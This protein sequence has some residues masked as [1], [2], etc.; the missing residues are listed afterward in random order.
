[1]GRGKNLNNDIIDQRLRN[2]T[3]S[4]VQGCNYINSR[5]KMWF[6]CHICGEEWSTTYNHIFNGTG[7]PSAFCLDCGPKTTRLND[8]I[9]DQRLVGRNIKRLSHCESG[10]EMCHFRCEDCN[11]HW[12]VPA[13]NVV[14][15]VNSDQLSGCPQCAGNLPITNEYVDKQLLGRN[16][17]RLSNIIGNNKD[18]IDFQCN[19][20]GY[21]WNAS[22]HN[23]IRKTHTTG[24]PKCA[25]KLPLSQ[26]E[27]DQGLIGRNIKILTNII[28]N[29][30]TSIDCKC[31]VC[32]YLWDTTIQRLIVDKHGCAGCAG[33]L[34]LTNEII[35]KSLANIA[36]Q[37]L[38]GRNLKRIGDYISKEHL[39]LEC[40]DCGHS[41]GV[42]ISN[43]LNKESGCPI[44]ATCKNEKLT[45]QT[46]LEGGL[47]IRKQVA[48]KKL[49]SGET[50][51]II[52]D[53]YLEDYNTIIEYNGKQ[54]YCPVRFIG[55][56]QEEAEEQFLKQQDR[57]KYLQDFCDVNQI[58]LIWIDGRKYTNSKLKNYINEIIV[59]N[60]HQ[61]NRKHND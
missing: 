12:F 54:H 18:P 46:L 41:W 20:D 6:W 38:I 53:F 32:G 7:C 42:Y 30:S 47:S 51:R 52:V 55:M 50:R 17:T 23:I 2:R 27:I 59:P 10:S 9:I 34:P 5:T 31:E 45:G 15:R 1:M 21:I 4:R 60:L 25:G 36:N 28:H 37:Q 26:D 3:L 61:K 13:N 57:D 49:L 22:P 33:I 11:Y 44:C 39:L 24:C 40:N 56:T 16:I 8:A 43:I 14:S 19:I 58:Q 29:N 35:D 48:I